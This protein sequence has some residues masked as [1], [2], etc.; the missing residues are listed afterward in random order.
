MWIEL[1][2]QFVVLV[3]EVEFVV[4]DVQVRGGYVL[5]SGI[6]EGTIK[7]GDKLSLHID[8]VTKAW[9]LEIDSVVQTDG[10]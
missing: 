10:R 5:H 8:E 9:F 6:V 1:S 2:D 3:Q 7:I 4:K